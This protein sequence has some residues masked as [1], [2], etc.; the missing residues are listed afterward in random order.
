M[1]KK[2]TTPSVIIGL[3][4]SLFAFLGMISVCG[5]PL[6]AAFLAWFGIGASQLG[7][8]S[9]YQPIF[10]TIAIIALLYGFYTIYFKKAHASTNCGKTNVQTETSCNS[11]PLKSRWVA[12]AMLWIAA[13]AIVS[14]YFMNTNTN[15]CN[16]NNSSCAV[17]KSEHSTNQ[18]QPPTFSCPDNIKN[19]QTKQLNDNCITGHKTCTDQ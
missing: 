4:S 6:L 15:M 9:E 8:L 13:L 1:K 17:K 19:N 16:N 3:L 11:A 12:K 7:I 14:T 10:M 2:N 5:F 18:C